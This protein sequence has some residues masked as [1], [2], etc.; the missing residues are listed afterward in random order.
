MNS[1]ISTAA[2]ETQGEPL[3]PAELLDMTSGLFAIFWSLPLGLLLYLRAIKIQSFDELRLPAYVI[4]PIACLWGL[5]AL[6]RVRRLT[7][8][9]RARINTARCFTFMQIY[10]A[11]FVFWWDRVGNRPFFTANI[12]GLFLVSV[13][14][15]VWLNWIVTEIGAALQLSAFT[16]EGRALT[17]MTA[18]VL[19]LPFILLLVHSVA[20]TARYGY[21]TPQLEM[22]SSLRDTQPWAYMLVLVPFTCT[23]VAL[24]RARDL[25]LSRVRTS[26]PVYRLRSPR[27]A[28]R[29]A[30]PRDDAAISPIAEADQGQPLSL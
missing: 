19:V 26:T 2:D 15:L 6:A 21:T 11:P 10:F 12:I 24:L 3:T 7:P 25:F 20:T 16:A 30:E 29:A 17:A 28:D 4:G 5:S 18:I 9:W 13:L 22:I 27:V 23:L 14:L 1:P 8:H